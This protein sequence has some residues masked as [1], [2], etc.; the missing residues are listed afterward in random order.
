[1]AAEKIKVLIVDDSALV[2]RLLLEILSAEPTF[3]VVGAASDPYIAREKIKKLNPDVVTLDVEMPRMDGITFLENLMRLHPMPVVMVSSLTQRGAEVTLR[4]LELGAVDFVAKP[5]VDVAGSLEGYGAEII[6]KVKMAA[7]ARVKPGPPPRMH[8]APK[9]VAPKHSAD[10]ILPPTTM[11]VM[12]KT[13]ERVI[14]IGASTG[15]TEALREVLSAMPPDAPGI[16]ICQHIPAAF[17]GP[18]AQRLDQTAAMSVCEAEDGQYILPGHAYV[19]PGDKHLVIERDGA[20]YKCRLSEG[21]PVNR[22]R[23]SVDVLFRSVAQKVGP[24]AIGAIL[25]G[26]GDDGARGL[27]EMQNA[28]APTIAQDEASSVVWGMPGSAVKLG[29]ADHIAPLRAIPELLLRLAKKHSGEQ[30]GEAAMQST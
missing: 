9:D 3:E 22:H 25:T 26:M 27:K 10:V 11:R 12:L 23:P 28:G 6:A 1:L 7:R 8:T 16:V 2:R 5:K 29:A 15:G 18:F 21:A 17:S 13:T 20:R 30:S 14:A 4:A 24:N 19:A